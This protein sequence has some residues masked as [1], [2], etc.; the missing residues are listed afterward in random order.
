MCTPGPGATLGKAFH[1]M[2]GLGWGKL[3]WVDNYLILSSLV[4]F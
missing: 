3:R 1:I 4:N 2:Y